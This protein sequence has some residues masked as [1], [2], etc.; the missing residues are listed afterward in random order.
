MALLAAAA[1]TAA[2]PAL[3]YAPFLVDEPLAYPLA[4]LALFAHR[5][6]ARTCRP[7]PRLAAAAAACLLGPLARTQL[8]VL[9]VV[10]AFG[11]AVVVWRS[12]RARRLR[13]GWTTDDWV[14]AA[15]LALGA[16]LVAL[17]FVSRRSTSWYVAT[18]FY[19]G[20]MLDFGLWANG[21]LALGLG[22]VPF[23]ATLVALASVRGRTL[24]D[25][26]RGFAITAAASLASFDRLR[27]GQGRLPLDDVR[28]PRAGAEPHLPDAAPLRRNGA[29][30]STGASRGS[31]ALVGACALTIWLI[32]DTPFGLAYP[33][34]EAHG[35]S[36]L[37]F[38][39]RVLRWDDTRHRARPDRGRDRGQRSCSACC[40]RRRVASHGRSGSP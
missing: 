5:P 15:T 17:A 2:A 4:T 21:A 16:V 3:V 34:Y 23:L 25:G 37:T 31:W 39:N 32:V 22:L 13:T 20:R 18:T 9:L 38:A 12:E 19:K 29:G 14:G 8:S 28:E 35:F 11:G 27:R 6:L 30:Y 24:T 1:G 10:L 33:N 36:I 26:E 7:W 40:A